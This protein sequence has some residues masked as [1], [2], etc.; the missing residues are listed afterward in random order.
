MMWLIE[1]N[2]GRQFAEAKTSLHPTATEVAQFEAD[3]VLQEGQLPR[4]VQVNGS[5]AQIRVEGILTKKPDILAAF[6]GGGNTTYSSI[7]SGLAAA[8]S[9]PGVSEVVMTVDSPGGEVNGLFDV[10]DAINQFKAGGKKI[11]VVADR[12]ASAAYAIAAAAGEIRASS[13]ASSFGSVGVVIDY[14]KDSKI[15]S[16][17]NSDSPNKRPD[18]DTEEG[19]A[20]VRAYL[21]QVHSLFI[22]AIASGRGTTAAKVNSDFGR[23]AMFVAAE[24]KRRK[25]I[26]ASPSTVL[27][28]VESAQRETNKETQ[29]DLSELKAQHPAVYSAAVREGINQERERVVAHLTAGEMS[30]DMETA[31]KSIRD[32][33]EMTMSLQTHYMMMG[34]NRA[35][36][37]TRQAEDEAAQAALGGAAVTATKGD[38]GD[39]VAALLLGD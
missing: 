28:A 37:K 29:M 33:A 4:N 14:I 39:K 24:A 3:A 31:A 38:M 30:G 32:G 12:A 35:H 5:T 7:I 20:Q 19:R 34:V 10:I 27:R 9:D 25:M 22:E 13:P 2:A 16:I 26:D 15:G 1:E 18:L 11:R 36:Q 23:G 17:T 6:F 8:Q 21:D